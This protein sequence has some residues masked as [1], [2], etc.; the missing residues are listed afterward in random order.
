MKII[1]ITLV[2]VILTISA[3]A[4]STPE[5]PTPP[6]TYTSG[7]SHTEVTT[8]SSRISSSTTVSDS[9]RQFKF[10][11]KFHS[12]KRE[13]VEH[14]LIDGLEGIKIEKNKREKLWEITKRG[15][16]IFE[17]SMSKNRMSIYLDKTQSTSKFYYKIKAIAE[18]LQEFISAHKR[19]TFHN[20]KRNSVTR[21][22]A[23]LER[24]KMELEASIK[25]L[26]KIKR[27]NEEN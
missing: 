11:S 21:A 26:R 4:Q 15:E 27:A 5:V 2:T 24:A 1:K 25:N 19:H 13:G 8:S 18:D 9:K 7:N 17:C 3:C 10:K 23:R 14:I 20:R 6:Q 16:V 12:S 22:E